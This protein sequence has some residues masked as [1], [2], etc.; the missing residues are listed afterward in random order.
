MNEAAYIALVTRL[1]T[2]TGLYPLLKENQVLQAKGSFSRATLIRS[3]P[4]QLTVGV[5]GRDLH[6]ALFQIDLMVPVNTGTTTVNSLADAVISMFPR[7]LELTAG[8]RVLHIIT[9]YRETA[10]RVNDQYHSVPVI[11]EVALVA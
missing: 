10:G 4:N 2:V 5:T 3:R 8:S 7:G 9:S 6:R 1:S 11:V